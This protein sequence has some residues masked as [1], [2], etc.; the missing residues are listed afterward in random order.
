MIPDEIGFM[1]HRKI[2]KLLAVAALMSLAAVIAMVSA[3]PQTYEGREPE[4]PWRAAAQRRIE[5]FRKGGLAVRVLDADGSPLEGVRVR[6]VQKRHRFRFGSMVSAERL[7]EDSPEG[8]LYREAFMSNFNSATVPKFYDFIWLDPERPKRSVPATLKCL[9]W[10]AQKGIATHGHVLVWNFGPGGRKS[11]TPPGKEDSE[12]RVARH[13]ERTIERQDFAAGVQRWDV[14]NEPYENSE[15]F[16]VLGVAQAAEWFKRA[17]RADPEAT[18][19]LNETGLCAMTVR[20]SWPDRLASTERLVNSLRDQG[21]PV[22]ALGIQS[23]QFDALTP[24]PRVWETLERLSKLNLELLITEYD[25]R[26]NP[27]AGRLASFEQRFRTPPDK[28]IRPELEQLEADYLRDYL[29][30]CFSHPAVTEFTIWGFW[31]GDHWLFNAPF[32]RKDWTERPALSAWRE[33]VYREWWTDLTLTTDRRGRVKTRG[34]LG[35]YDLYLEDELA[36][37]VV[38]ERHDQTLEIVLQR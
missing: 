27:S 10:L 19:I 1:V 16:E 24:I 14:L 17:H 26:T 37:S 13:F 33:L 15:A 38:L 21:A 23:H 29:T 4:A 20:S 8:D 6:I 5:K 30:V 3:G 22:H 9:E 7:I 25:A 36:K 12:E 34:F 11:P 31:D 32:Y 2:L 35:D 18:L 28:P